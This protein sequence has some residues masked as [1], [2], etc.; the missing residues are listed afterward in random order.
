MK[1]VPFTAYRLT[2][3]FKVVE[4]VIVRAEPS[5]LGG[6]QLT[7]VNGTYRNSASLYDTREAAIAAGSEKLA[8]KAE[9]RIVESVEDAK[10]A[11]Q[12]A[13]EAERGE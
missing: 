7:D 1:D 4:T 2:P 5:W 9:R 6:V 13:K 3:G 10:R 11:K 8:I 12:L